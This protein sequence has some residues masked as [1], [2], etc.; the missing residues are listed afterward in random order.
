MDID[1]TVDFYMR[2]FVIGYIFSFFNDIKCIATWALGDPAFSINV[3]QKAWRF[4]DYDASALGDSD[5][6]LKK[7]QKK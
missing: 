4:K 3:C 6:E 2:V 7:K 1:I 5:H